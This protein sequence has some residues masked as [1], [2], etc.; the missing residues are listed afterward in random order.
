MRTVWYWAVIEQHEGEYW[1]TLPDLPGPNSADEDVNQALRLLAEFAAEH[2]AD[3][4]ERKAEVPPARN[5]DDI[6]H[7]PDV[8]EWGRAMVPVDVPGVPVKISLS[9]EESLLAR[10]D[11]AATEEG[12]TRSG[13]I[14]AAIGQRLRSLSGSADAKP[15]PVVTGRLPIHFETDK[16]GRIVGTIGLQP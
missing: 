16:D 11:R 8:K 3:L 13:F 14:A 12:L 2:V 6:E 1:V 4:V 9:I 10:A 15:V 5:V 7:D